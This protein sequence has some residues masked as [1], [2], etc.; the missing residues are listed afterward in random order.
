MHWEGVLVGATLLAAVTA[1]PEVT[2]GLSAIKA[3]K[4]ELAIS[5]IIGGN[6]FL[7]VLF[8]FGTLLSGEAI[9]PDAKGPDLYLTALG[10]LLT[11]VYCAG[12]LLRS[13]QLVFGAGVDSILVL[14][15]YIAG[16][17]GLFFVRS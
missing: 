14:A 5:D 17:V 15:L 1:L 2:T 8:L 9:L 13:K 4:F 6:A 16:I 10:G 3:G 7:P 12:A 11:A